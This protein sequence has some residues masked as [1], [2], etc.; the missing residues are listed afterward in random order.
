[1][2][3]QGSNLVL[4]TDNAHEVFAD[5]LKNPRGSALSIIKNQPQLALACIQNMDALSLSNASAAKVL[6]AVIG[7]Q[8][9]SDGK[10]LLREHL[11]Q[12]RLR[13]LLVAQGDL[14]STAALIADVDTVALAVAETA[15]EDIDSLRRWAYKLKD[16]PDYDELLKVVINE[17]SFLEWIV[18]AVDCHFQNEGE[19]PTSAWEELGVDWETALVKHRELT[20]LGFLPLTEEEAE[21]RL[22]EDREANNAPTSAS[23]PI[24]PRVEDDK[25]D[26][27]EEPSAADEID[28]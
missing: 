20:A 25:H 11:T 17:R 21:D 24:A 5:F 1:M 4:S 28:L 12:H 27:K 14:A 22:E 18:V 2:S 15:V 19:I 7:E 9:D 3:D 8:H 23:T 10:V 26:D 13:E 6:D 16:R